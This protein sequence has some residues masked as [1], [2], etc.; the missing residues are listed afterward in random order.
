[1]TKRIS[2]AA[3]LALLGTGCGGSKGI[4][5][6]SG[7]VTY[8]GQPASGAKVLFRRLEGASIRDQTMMG[9]VEKDGGFTVDCGTLGKGA[10]AGEYAVLI[11]WK[12]DPTSPP[13]RSP[14]EA[15][16]RGDR[17]KGRYADPDHPLLRVTIRPGKNVLPPNTVR[18][19]C[20]REP[21]VCLP[22]GRDRRSPARCTVRGRQPRG[23]RQP[24]SRERPA[25]PSKPGRRPRSGRFPIR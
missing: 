19:S 16:T 24:G 22:T 11:E 13:A 21:S 15:S 12:Y 10:P 8:Q 6:V 7:K 3:L 23:A 1:M 2:V 20:G 17:M 4:Y 18:H 25:R 9:V 5:P 14:A